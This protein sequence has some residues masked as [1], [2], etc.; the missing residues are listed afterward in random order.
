MVIAN[1]VKV[2]FASRYL[3]ASDK[4]SAIRELV[5][6][7]KDSPSLKHP[8]E[9]LEDVLKR[10]EVGSTVISAGVAIPHARTKGVQN[11]VVSLGISRKGIDYSSQDKAFI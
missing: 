8:H 9:F 11:F 2:S 4:Y 5:E 6:A 7:V 1:N 10:E 3:E